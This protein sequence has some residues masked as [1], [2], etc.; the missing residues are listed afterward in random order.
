MSMIKTNSAIARGDAFWNVFGSLVYSGC[1][2][3]ILVAT[4]KLSSSADVGRI[5]LG[6][7]I[8]AP[9]FLLLQL[10]L[11]AASATDVKHAF[12]AGDYITLRIA[13]TVLA[14]ACTLAVCIATRLTRNE[15]NIVLLVATAKAIECGSDLFYGL[16]QQADKLRAVALSLTL[17]GLLAG[18]AFTV[19][20]ACTHRADYAL[21]V[22]CASWFI[23]LVV[24]DL[25]RA[26]AASHGRWR[27]KTSRA[28]LQQLAVLTLPLGLS[29]MFMS[30]MAN[31]PRYFIQHSLGLGALGIFSAAGYLTMTVSI[32]ISALAEAGIARMARLFADGGHREAARLLHRIAATTLVLS[33]ASIVVSALFGQAILKAVYRAEYGSAAQ[34]LT[35]LLLAGTLANLASVYGYALLAARRF[36]P[37]LGCLAASSGVTA[38]GCAF[39]IPRSGLKGAVWACLLGYGVQ[40]TCSWWMLRA[41]FAPKRSVNLVINATSSP[42]Y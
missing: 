23:V 24:F 28:R 22:L 7:A 20:L 38:A 39:L 33:A 15:T 13:C 21:G 30:L 17:R 34:L 19:T 37:Y 6:F 26:A 18:I 1:Q 36:G 9:I 40:A 5:S 14:F 32:V 35:G 11:R 16:L 12:S 3:G 25:P 8:S 41:E 29:T 42:G 27:L 10:R 4:V 31:M 2:W